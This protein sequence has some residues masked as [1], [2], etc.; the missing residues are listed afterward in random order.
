MINPFD[1]KGSTPI[2]DP[3]AEARIKRINAIWKTC[4]L[5]YVGA[6]GAL[7]VYWEITNSGPPM[8]VCE[9]QVRFFERDSCYIFLNVF[10]SL[11]PA[12]IPVFFARMLII[13]ITGVVLKPLGKTK[14]F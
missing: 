13:K 6:V 2:A 1:Y 7:I 10:A 12:L 11:L 5:I 14:Y 8:M 3:I 4:V 9:W